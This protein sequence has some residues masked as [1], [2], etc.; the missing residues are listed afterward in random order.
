MSWKRY[1]TNVPTADN[2]MGNMSPFSGRGGAEPGPAR[3]N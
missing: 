2:S 1:F 3:S